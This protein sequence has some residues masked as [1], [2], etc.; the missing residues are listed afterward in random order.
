MGNK[1]N[2][3]TVPV[4]QTNLFD[5]LIAV[6]SGL[7]NLL[8]VEKI[9]CITVLYLLLRDMIF[10]S[11]LSQGV[12]Y[13]NYLI[14]AGIIERIFENDNE[15]IFVMA[16]VIFVLIIIVV[17]LILNITLVYKREIQRLA[18]ERKDLLHNISIGRF[19]PLKNHN[20]SEEINK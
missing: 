14:D 18:D 4:K 15:V 13:Q 6:G 17:L 12:D 1:R 20:T 2:N 7:V 3:K 16:C 19:E 8:K 11:K 9:V 5:F 10:A